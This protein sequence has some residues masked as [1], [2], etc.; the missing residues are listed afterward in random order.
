MVSTMYNNGLVFSHL[1]INY[2]QNIFGFLELYWNSVLYVHVHGYTEM[3]VLTDEKR[4]NPYTK[5]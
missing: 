1:S 5:P 2:I 4:G 3:N